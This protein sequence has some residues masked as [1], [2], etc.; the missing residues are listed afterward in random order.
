MLLVWVANRVLFG[1]GFTLVVGWYL[2][3]KLRIIPGDVQECRLANGLSASCPSRYLLVPTL[4]T[5]KEVK[6]ITPTS[7]SVDGGPVSKQ[8]LPT[9]TVSEVNLTP[10]LEYG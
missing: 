4:L 9:G 10:T 2:R 6:E 7:D 1:K 8:H 5:T 3:T